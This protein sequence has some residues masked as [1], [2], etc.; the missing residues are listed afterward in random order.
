M[1]TFTKAVE[2]AAKPVRLAAERVA[3]AKVHGWKIKA[4]DRALMTAQWEGWT[5]TAKLIVKARVSC[6]VPAPYHIFEIWYEAA[7]P[8]HPTIVQRPVSTMARVMER[9]VR[10]AIAAA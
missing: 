9:A 3:L 4:E 1:T 8:H 2:V 6:H 7:H 5:I 10:A